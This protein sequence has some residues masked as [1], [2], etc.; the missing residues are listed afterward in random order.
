VSKRFKKVYLEI[1]NKCNLQCTFCPPVERPDHRME[2]ASFR[3]T[4]AQVKPHADMVCFHLMGEPLGHPNFINFVNIAAEQEVPVEITTNGTLL[5]EANELALL[6]PTIR[7]VNFSLQSFMDNFPNASVDSY[8]ARIFKF[9]QNAFIKRPD[10]YIN[11]RLW[12]LSASDNEDT[13]NTKLLEQ[14]EST[15]A[16]SINRRID[17]RLQKSKHLLNRLYIHYDTRF[18]WPGHTPEQSRNQGT[19]HGTRSHVGILSNGTVVPCCLDKEANIA[20]GTLQTQAFEEI[21]N[22]D[23]LTQMRSGFEKN[24]LV[25]SFCQSCQFATRFA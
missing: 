6:N 21:I 1:G 20:L 19:C 22:S 24:V 7:Q 14:I 16:V 17:A 18:E 5:N 11:Y 8:L 12:N 4:L 3:K 25:E 23:R 9:T 13:S 10:L 2:E 15:F